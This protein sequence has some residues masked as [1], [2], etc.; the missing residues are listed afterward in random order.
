[1][2]TELAIRDSEGV[3]VATDPN[4]LWHAF[5]SPTHRLAVFLHGLG[6][7]ERCWNNKV[8]EP[9]DII[10][11]PDTLAADSFTPVLIRYNTGRSVLDNGTALALRME[12]LTA[13]WPVAVDEIALI[14]H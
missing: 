5:P 2:H 6:K 1:M 11:L 3:F 7:T 9:E 14:G 10:G 8:E 4:S 13:N 12:E